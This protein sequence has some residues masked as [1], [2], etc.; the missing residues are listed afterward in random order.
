MT[1]VQVAQAI[2]KSRVWCLA[3]D[4]T[5]TGRRQFVA[6]LCINLLL[7]RGCSV[8]RVHYLMEPLVKLTDQ[9]ISIADQGVSR[10]KEE[11]K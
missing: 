3:F 5:D 9:L 2:D 8:E 10:L 6:A 7:D 4:D 1:P 11:G